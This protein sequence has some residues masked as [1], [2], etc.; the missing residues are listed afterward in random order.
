MAE[1]ALI[2]YLRFEVPV[3]HSYVV[4]VTDGRH[5]LPHDA[6]RLCLAEVLLPADP[7]QQLASTQQLQN[8]ERVE[9]Q[10]KH[11]HTKHL[12]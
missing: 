8:Q 1:K 2:Q 7:L 4:H 10:R 3:H 11:T 9:L 6:A 5:Q 12:K